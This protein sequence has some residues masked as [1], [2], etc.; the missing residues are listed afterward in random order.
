MA[1]TVKRPVPVPISES[2][3]RLS[4]QQLDHVIQSMDGEWSLF[5]EICAVA[6]HRNGKRIVSRTQV[7]LALHLLIKQGKVKRRPS[8]TVPKTEYA[9]AEET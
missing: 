9:L 5:D 6:H 4:D 8:S 1:K 2:V 7:M 3:M